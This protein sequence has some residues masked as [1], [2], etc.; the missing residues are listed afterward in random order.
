MT[1][2]NE[3]TTSA[4]PLRYVGVLL[5][6]ILTGSWGHLSFLYWSSPNEPAALHRVDRRLF[7][8]ASKPLLF[9][10]FCRVTSDRVLCSS[11]AGLNCST[12]RWTFPVIGEST[13]HLHM[14]PHELSKVTPFF[15]GV[16]DFR[17]TK[18]RAATR[19]HTIVRASCFERAYLLRN[20]GAFFFF[21]GYHL[22]K[23]GWNLALAVFT[24]RWN[25]VFC[26][27]T[28]D[29]ILRISVCF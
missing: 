19:A 25:S 6:S 10:F 27:V 15:S 29:F 22:S 8:Q 7:F 3:L 9:F 13:L 1:R 23:N 11:F 26:G 12:R 5:Y 17:G 4:R 28:S 2:Y 18:I 20:S 16:S 21:G 14:R 24:A